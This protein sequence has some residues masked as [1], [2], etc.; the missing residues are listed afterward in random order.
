MDLTIAGKLK[1]REL[2]LI[3]TALENEIQRRKEFYNSGGLGK[4]VSSA[5]VAYTN[6]TDEMRELLRELDDLKPVR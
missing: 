2:A 5:R 3:R 4:V 6:V 1:L